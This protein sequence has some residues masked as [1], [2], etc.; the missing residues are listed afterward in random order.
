MPKN[1]TA[2]KTTA[3]TTTSLLMMT[4]T[5]IKTMAAKSGTSTMTVSMVLIEKRSANSLKMTRQSTLLCSTT[6]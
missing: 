1:M 3:E 5:V 2:D 6:L 4:A